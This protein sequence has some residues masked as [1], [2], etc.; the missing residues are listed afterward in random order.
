M[1]KI[2]PTGSRIDLDPQEVTRCDKYRPGFKKRF[3][4]AKKIAAILLDLMRKGEICGCDLPEEIDYESVLSETGRTVRFGYF[5]SY[6]TQAEDKMEAY[7]E[8]DVAK[9]ERGM[10]GGYE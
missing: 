2:D 7:W 9:T 4:N 1:K 5:K 6:P 8:K 3:E 10:H